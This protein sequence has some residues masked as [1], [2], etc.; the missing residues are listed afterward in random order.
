MQRF[1]P[2]LF[3]GSDDGDIPV[4]NLDLERWL[5]KPKGHERHIHGR[6]HA[7]L[8]IVV[9]GPTFLPALEAHLSRTQAVTGQE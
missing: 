9:K 8:R 6:Q 7:G 4:D 2:G 3:T 1:E 5:K